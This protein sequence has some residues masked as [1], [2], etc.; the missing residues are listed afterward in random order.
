MIAIELENFAQRNDVLL[1]GMNTLS[2]Q[3]FFEATINTAIGA[4][5]GSYTLDFFA[6]YDHILVLD[7][8]ILSVKI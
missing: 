4:G 2:S 3:I 5:S 7:R 1:S 8:G 6:W